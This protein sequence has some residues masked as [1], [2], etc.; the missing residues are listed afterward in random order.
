MKKKGFELSSWDLSDVLPENIEKKCD[1]I[2]SL[3]KE[4]EGLRTKLNPEILKEDFIPIVRLFE[5]IKTELYKIN[6]GAYM[7]FSEDILNNNSSQLLSTIE[8]FDADTENKILF[9]ETWLEK[10][11][12]D[13]N[14]ERLA[15]G[16]DDY[17]SY[18]RKVR[19]S[20][21][22]A[23]SEE[24]EKIIN[25]KDTTGTDILDKIFDKLTSSFKFTMEVNG[26][27]KRINE[28][29]VTTYFTDKNPKKRAEAYAKLNRK[30]DDFVPVLGELYIGNI[31]D[32]YNEHVKTRGYPSPISVRNYVNDISDGVVETLLEVCRNNRDVFQ[33][34]FKL[35]AR[36]CKI[37]G[38]I[39]RTDI[40]API[41]GVSNKTFEFNDASN[42]ILSSFES[43][44]PKFAQLALNIFK[45]K[46]IHSE[47]GKNKMIND[48]CY[49]TPPEIIPYVLIN[50]E[51][52]VDDVFTLA[53][54][55][56]H[57]I[58]YQLSTEEHGILTFDSSLPLSETASIFCEM[59]L[60]DKLIVDAGNDKKLKKEILADQLDDAYASIIRQAY[61]VIFEKEA[62]DMINSSNGSSIEKLSDL[63]Y[64]KL[65]EQFGD[66]LSEIPK[67][68]RSEWAQIPHIYQSPFY[69]YAYAFGQLLTL[70]L[71]QKYQEE[72]ASFI[73]QYE[74]ILAYGGSAP[75][76]KILN[77]I[78]IDINSNKFWQKGF[79]IIKRKVNELESLL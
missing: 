47:T 29:D 27:R 28:T 56:G 77:E 48:Y 44:S 38:K 17:E 22:F 36:L 14:F 42:L 18:L 20:R 71:Y 75:P 34:Y 59:M 2:K 79:D 73:P 16:T 19:K 49:G 63:Y 11:L 69:C 64:D 3:A 58:H 24:V 6:I 72:G 62:H 67:Y 50:F 51:E 12:D 10:E 55:L 52:A 43:F 70:S 35:K 37:P 76:E 7:K 61:I 30:Y 5:N 40:Y 31:R 4:F 8:N 39:S 54:E 9:F 74:K 60:T 25:L 32:W 65:K 57:G 78:G 23:L 21:K 15:T 68:F 46:H 41:A 1:E 66:S 33:E 53:H 13:Q 26:K 45:H